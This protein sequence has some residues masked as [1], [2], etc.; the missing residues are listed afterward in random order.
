MRSGLI[1]VGVSTNAKWS[2]PGEARFAQNA[3]LNDAFSNANGSLA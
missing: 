2:A 3:T 1:A